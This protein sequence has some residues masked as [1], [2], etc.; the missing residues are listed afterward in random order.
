[1]GWMDGWM[2]LSYTTVTPRASLQSDANN[3]GPLGKNNEL[4]SQSTHLDLWRVDV[5]LGVDHG[6]EHL[7]KAFGL[8]FQEG[9]HLPKHGLLQLSHRLV[10]LDEGQ[11]ILGQ[12]RR[13]CF[14]PGKK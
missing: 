10:L 12:S 7:Y 4:S 9:N 2:G 1:M 6:E 8:V 13:V 5:L 3:S 14:T 11:G